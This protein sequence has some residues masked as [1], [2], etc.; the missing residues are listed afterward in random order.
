MCRSA[1]SASLVSGLAH[2]GSCWAPWSDCATASTIFAPVKLAV[3]PELVPHASL[4]SD[5]GQLAAITVAAI[6]IGTCLAAFTELDWLAQ[7]LPSTTISQVL[8]TLS[9]HPGLPAGMLAALCGVICLTGIIA[10]FRVPVLPARSPGSPAHQWSVFAL[11]H[12]VASLWRF[13]GVMQPAV[14]LGGFWALGAVAMAGLPPLALVVF[15]AHAAGTIGLFLC[16]VVG[17]VVGSLAAGR[18][19]APAVPAGLPVVGALIAGLSLLMV[20]WDA[21]VASHLPPAARSMGAIRCCLLVTGI[22]AGLWE[23]PLTV[24]LQQR[25]PLASRG[26]VMS[27]TSAL[28]S[29]CTVLAT[30]LYLLL[31][32]PLLTYL[33]P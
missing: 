22:G 14:A 18:M 2:P 23:V 11:W 13:P 20:G 15:N 17:M 10:A 19:V 24:L 4:G 3:V 32:K 16:L 5:N 31:T 27:A 7:L 25:T 30:G 12:Q 6:L 28:A 8:Q 29:I 9:Q 1:S 33:R 26:A 21:Q